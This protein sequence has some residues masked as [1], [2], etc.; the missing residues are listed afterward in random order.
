MYTGQL[1]IDLIIT[2]H[3]IFCDGHSI[4]VILL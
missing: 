4:E 1:W 3:L 2:K